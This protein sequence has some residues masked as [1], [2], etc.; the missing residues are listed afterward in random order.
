MN[1]ISYSIL[2]FIKKV[3]AKAVFLSFF[4]RDICIQYFRP[5][6]IYSYIIHEHYV[7]FVS[8]YE[9]YNCRYFYLNKIYK[10]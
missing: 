5:I 9:Y 1:E 4:T 8:E 6:Y 7:I 2:I 10:Y 3:K